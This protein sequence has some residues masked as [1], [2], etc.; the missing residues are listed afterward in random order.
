LKGNHAMLKKIVIRT[1]ALVAAVCIGALS[2]SACGVWNWLWERDYGDTLGTDD[3]FIGNNGMESETRF[4][5]AVPYE[6]VG[7]AHGG[8]DIYYL[9]KE[10]SPNQHRIIVIDPGH[11]IRGSSE[12]EPNGP[13]SEDM[14]AEVTWG[15]TGK[16]TGQTEYELNLQVAL[17]LRDE[18]IKRGYSVVMIRETNAVNISNMERAQ[19]ANKYKADA[20][21]RIHANGYDDETMKGAMTICQS[22]NNPYADCVAHYEESRK[23]S[24][25]VLDHFCEQ[26]GMTKLS[27]REM[28]NMTGTNW[29]QVPTTI[30][31]MGFLSNK[32]DDQLMLTEFFRYK[33]ASGI[34]DGL[35]QY[36]VWVEEQEN[37][38]EDTLPDADAAS[39]ESAQ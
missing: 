15:A 33:A 10:G 27:V 12:K 2:L 4:E 5:G 6:G 7:S 14:K 35:D 37:P 1:V 22:R 17:L 21:V 11:Q 3:L 36:F 16:Y 18:L 28:D 30:V 23:L 13:G 32:L 29:S 24:S 9:G 19:I 38:A 26:T 39:S 20:Y 25:Y 34:A 8:T 31:E